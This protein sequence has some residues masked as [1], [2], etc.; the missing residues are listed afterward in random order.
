MLSNFIFFVKRTVIRPFMAGAFTENRFR[1]F[2]YAI[3]G[4]FL[5]STNYITAK[6]ALEGFNSNTFSLV[7][8]SAATV[9]SFIWISASI[10]VRKILVPAGTAGRLIL[11]G[12]ITG[13]GMILSW[14]GLR[15]LDPSFNSFLTRF[16]PVL[17]ILLSVFV[18]KEK[19]SLGILIPFAV[20]V[21]GSLISSLGRWEIVGRGVVLTLSACFVV[22][23]QMLL[24]K[25]I[26]RKVHP[27]VLV[28]YRTLFGALTILI[29]ILIIGDYD[30]NVAPKYWIVTLIGAFLG[31]CASYML[32]Y[33]SYR[34]WD[35]SKYSIVI[36]L[37]PLFVLPLAYLFLGR[38]PHIR[39]LLGGLIIMVGGF[40]LACLYFH[41]WRKEKSPVG[42]I[43]NS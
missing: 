19:V 31:P 14:A 35:L 37:Q 6:F 43:S 33:R 41:P 23:L 18:L 17:T 36:T 26:V 13:T 15:L 24:A 20:M 16:V 32:T 40:W 22:S 4:I 9:Y 8:T 3:G 1:G 21:G 10:G 39:E 2:L 25:V 28:V 5:L 42:D 34:Y 38:F 12:V 27:N 29:W 30:F 11:L 7:W